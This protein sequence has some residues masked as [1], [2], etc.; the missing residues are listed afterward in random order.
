MSESV[1]DLLKKSIYYLKNNGVENS[2][3]D[4]QLLLCHL[5]DVD[6]L[7][8]L[9]NQDRELVDEEIIRY[10][11]ILRLRDEGMPL[12]YITGVQE[13]MS[14]PFKVSKEVLI[15]RGD[16][17]ALVE[18]VINWCKDITA[19]DREKHKLRAIDIGTGSGCIA[20]SLAHYIGNIEITA[21]DI[22]K[23][24]LEIATENAKVNGVKDRVTFVQH[25]I[26]SGHLPKINRNSLDIIAS[27]PPYISTDA[28]N[29]LQREVKDYEPFGALNGG[30]DGLIF[31]RE[32]IKMAN[33]YLKPGGVIVLEVGHD[34]SEA[35]SA[36][37]K[38]A[39]GY[40][41]TQI[42]KDLAGIDRVIAATYL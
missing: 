34:Q 29:G 36:L 32:I 5:L 9:T 3:L 21:F 4:A 2:I 16:T 8:V 37:I 13:F 33:K 40:L 28:I 14:L 30:A 26:L 17:E 42:I 22:S 12:Q 25:D 10:N 27:N 1:R 31:Y 41:S 38:K 11:H 20:V 18:Y 39:E 35:V 15:P 19:K 6:R 7:Y 23:S 24:A